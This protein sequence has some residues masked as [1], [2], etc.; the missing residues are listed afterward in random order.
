MQSNLTFENLVA[1]KKSGVG[2]GAVSDAELRLLANRVA[3]LDIAA[4]PEELAADLQRIYSQ[5]NKM[6]LNFY[7]LA[8]V[9]A[10]QAGVE[11]PTLEAFQ[12]DPLRTNTLGANDVTPSESSVERT[13]TGGI[14]IRDN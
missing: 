12:T 14:R 8:V 1:L 7:D 11:K 5:Y 9:A 13:G 2:L 10:E 3:V 6:K 4:K